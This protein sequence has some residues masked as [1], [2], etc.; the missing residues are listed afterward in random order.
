MVDYQPLTGIDGGWSNYLESNRQ[1]YNQARQNALDSEATRK[2][3]L[4]MQV[5]NAL[6]SGDNQGALNT[7]LRGG[8]FSTAA[9]IRGWNETD[10]DRA[11]KQA[12]LKAEKT[13]NLFDSI[14]SASDPAAAFEHAAQAGLKA[15]IF[16]PQDIES[17]RSSVK[18]Y[19]VPEAMKIYAGQVGKQQELI[20]QQTEQRQLEAKQMA[21]GLKAANGDA[22]REKAY[23]NFWKD[24][25]P[26]LVS[27]FLTPEG[28]IKPGAREAILGLGGAESEKTTFG[29]TPQYYTD[30]NGQLRIGQLSSAGGMKSVEVPGKL[31]PS[32]QFRDTGTSL[33]GVNTRTGT[34][35]TSIPKDVA[36]KESM[37]EQGKAQ[38]K[39]AADLPR[40]VENAQNGLDT[41]AAIRK[42]PG[43]SAATGWSYY[44]S[45][46]PGTESRS[47]LNH[48]KQAQGQSFLQ[49]FNSLKGGG[50]ITEIEGEKATQAIA[51]LDAPQDEKD[52]DQALND[53]E[54]IIRRGMAR[55]K[56][57]AV[58]KPVLPSE[59]TTKKEK[60]GPLRLRYNPETGELE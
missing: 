7:S 51:R 54:M 16:T 23:L 22:V 30:E 14:A 38:G 48:L 46:L 55:A 42:H 45:G 35:V 24:K 41:I 5:G 28:E 53:L 20:K 27:Q 25:R 17:A 49:A 40:I 34:T 59:D 60:V 12:Q 18:Q 21:L 58:A 32:L 43:K 26:D 50:Q 15:G 37:E 10:Q 52:F 33:E 8:D 11:L 56:A 57:S 1:G 39:A 19:G 4:G 2:R 3:E 47:F 9:A 31:A 36:G 29:M 6:A 44:V 13:Y